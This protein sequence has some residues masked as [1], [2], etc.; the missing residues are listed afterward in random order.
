MSSGNP[1]DQLRWALESALA[2]TLGS[3]Q[4]PTSN[5][6]QIERFKQR[7]ADLEQQLRQQKEALG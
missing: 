1:K 5:N 2:K 4:P 3:M 7:I 6:L